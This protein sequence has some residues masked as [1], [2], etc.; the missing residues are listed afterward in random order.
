MENIKK[1]LKI[2]AIFAYAFVVVVAS[3]GAMNHGHTNG[4]GIYMA[5]GGLNLIA[6]IWTAYKAYHK[7]QEK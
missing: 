4:E 6:G 2:L 3:A 1:W 7:T 5:M